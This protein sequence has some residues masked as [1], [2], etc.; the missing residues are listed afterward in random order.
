M[1]CPRTFLPG[2]DRANIASL[3]RQASTDLDDAVLERTRVDSRR[4]L[5]L[6]S[7]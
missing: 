3:G 1:V 4:R 5:T 2:V 6:N 7:H